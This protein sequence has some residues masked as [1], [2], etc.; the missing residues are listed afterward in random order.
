[1]K[2]F[3]C[4]LLLGL[5]ATFAEE[6]KLDEGVL[7]LTEQNFDQAITDNKFVLVEFCK[8]LPFFFIY[9][10]VVIRWREKRKKISIV[11]CLGMGGM[12][13]LVAGYFDS[14]QHE[15]ICGLRRLTIQLGN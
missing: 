1:M 3:A 13:F 10:S 4:F 6:I 12:G 2:L 5:G 14:G 9:C 8:Y 15:R 7:V 11:C